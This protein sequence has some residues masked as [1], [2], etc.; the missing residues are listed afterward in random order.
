MHRLRLYKAVSGL[1]RIQYR[2]KILLVAFAG[3]QIPLLALILYFARDVSPTGNMD[4]KTLG[5]VIIATLSGTAISLVLLNYLLQPIFLTARS[6]S[7]YA[8]DGV[9]PQLPVQFTDEAGTLMADTQRAILKLD[10]SLR[11][12]TDFDHVTSLPTRHTFMRLLSTDIQVEAGLALCAIN[13]NN[14]DKIAAAFGQSAVNSVMVAIAG[15]LRGLLGDEVPLSRVGSSTFIF[16]LELY[17]GEMQL[18]SRI[19]YIRLAVE[20]ELVLPGFS[21]RPEM[22]AGVTL[23]TGGL[24]DAERLINEAVS[25]LVDTHF[26]SAIHTNFF[27][28]AQ[29]EQARDVFLLERDLRFAIEQDQFTVHYQPIVDLHLGRVVGAEALVRWTHPQRGMVSPA[30]FIPIAE[31]SGLMDAIGMSVLKQVCRQLGQWAGTPLDHIKVSINLSARQ[32][33]NPDAVSQIQDAL[34]ANHVS[35]TNLEIEL[36]ETTVIQ[37]TGR[38][39]LIL[40]MLRK[41]GIT[42][43]IDDFGTGYSGLSY[44]KTLP[45]DRLKIDREF[46]QNVDKTVTSMAI[47]KSLI[48]LASGLG[49]EVL[50]EGTE[51]ASEVGM[52]HSLGCNLYQGFHFSRPLS[53]EKF[54]DAVTTIELGLTPPRPAKVEPTTWNQRAGMPLLLPH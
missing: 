21:L 12:L 47:C 4:L 1:L 27:S 25:A 13:V 30:A 24:L 32:F 33:L 48:E 10:A 44:L 54:L 18:A 17:Q 51:T 42:I 52:M 22:N 50:A 31:A 40:Q 14:Y 26:E 29:N 37:D 6:L 20:R 16:T 34:A 7:L 45:F 8:Q 53:A 5:I 35:P 41:M 43:A 28:S 23:H 3:G 39:V 15:R 38:T 46:I 2:N 11:Q 49:I 9:L 19:E 36:T